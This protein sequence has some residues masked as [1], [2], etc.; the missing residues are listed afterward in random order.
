[1]IFECR[2]FIND[3]FLNVNF[4][5]RCGV[6]EGLFRR[7]ISNG[8]KENRTDQC[9]ETVWAAYYFVS[10]TSAVTERHGWFEPVV[11]H[12]LITKGMYQFGKWIEVLYNL[13][14]KL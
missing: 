7:A 11:S 3:R 1:M 13:V 8:G 12:L 14:K 2:C 5:C 4:E 6:D 9:R 10:W